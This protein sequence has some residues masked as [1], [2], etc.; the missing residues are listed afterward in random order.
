[1]SIERAI[2]GSF[3]NGIKGRNQGFQYYTYTLGYKDIIDSFPFIDS[4]VVSSYRAPSTYGYYEWF[5]G[6]EHNIINCNKASEMAKEE[7][8]RCFS[9]CKK[10]IGDKEKA[11]F[12]YAKDLGFDWTG[13]RP[14]TPYQC[15][16][17]CDL[18]DVTK[19]P[20]FYCSSPVVCCDILRECFFPNDN[21]V[22]DS[23]F[24]KNE[25]SLDSNNDIQLVHTAGFTNITLDEILNFINEEG[26][27]RLHTLKS[28]VTSLLKLKDGD[29][30]CRIVLADSKENNVMWIAALSYIFPV[31]NCLNLSFT[32]YGYSIT[33]FDINGV[34]VAALN[35]VSEEQGMPS[36]DYEFSKVVS[37]FS[38]YDFKE[39]YFAPNVEVED[40]L[41]MSMIENSFT[42]NMD[43]LLDAYKQYIEEFTTYRQLNSKYIW[44]YYLY[45]LLHTKMTLSNSDLQ[46]GLEFALEY[47]LETEKTLVLN[48]FFE[49][50]DKYSTDEE[51]IS[52]FCKY[53][54][55]L[56]TEKNILSKDIIINRFTSYI[57]DLIANDSFD[58]LHKFSNIVSLTEKICELSEGELETIIVGNLQFGAIANI[59][60]TVHDKWKKAYLNSAICYYI[61]SEKI[62][63]KKD[64]AL[65]NV[66]V[67]IVADIIENETEKELKIVDKFINQSEKIITETESWFIYNDAINRALLSKNYELLSNT[68]ITAI[69]KKY[70]NSDSNTKAA[71]V[72]T[73]TKYSLPDQYILCIIQSIS[74]LENFDDVLK[75]YTVLIIN[76]G[77]DVQAYVGLIKHFVHEGLEKICGNAKLSTQ[78]LFEAYEFFKICDEKCRSDFEYTEA[79]TLIEAYFSALLKEHDNFII[80]HDQAKELNYLYAEYVKMGGK[81]N[82]AI[83]SAFLLINEMSSNTNNKGK[84]IFTG[85]G[86]NSIDYSYLPQKRKSSFLQST[87]LFCSK[88]WANNE[89]APNFTGLF[90]VSDKSERYEA[91]SILLAKIANEFIENNNIKNRYRYIADLIEYGIVL[92]LKEYLN[93]IPSVI[94]S[95]VK[96]HNVVKLLKKDFDDKI[97][98]K[99]VSEL[100]EHV[101]EKELGDIIEK[102]MVEY[103]SKESK[104]TVGK[105]KKFWKNLNS[106]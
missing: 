56:C 42:V 43:K 51:A 95:K 33:D 106:Q 44:G 45:V 57:T 64:D 6:V 58:N 62:T 22:I 80:S 50:I 40:N 49:N 1:M 68:V 74:R 9:F 60:S 82:L 37:S 46:G 35:N 25:C 90:A 38:V 36:T 12:I 8:P 99:K 32:T 47:A 17:I 96:Q 26:E 88:Y 77:K 91:M 93:S 79:K 83:V 2:Y 11:V 13:Q 101:D 86:I 18:S 28:L 27:E 89:I 78:I 70:I 103:E 53:F 5:S 29:L 21:S 69:A 63:I 15:A 85:E 7:H 10:N 61:R 72:K 102:I 19:S 14:L 52:I 98:H 67:K 87:A 55:Q 73:V 16:T 94:S 75:N 65:Y 3:Q 104:T 23:S 66:V 105:I 4:M 71:I 31:K 81:D 24:L 48:C 100:I 97:H 54:K 92:C 34:Y 76:N 41:F 39:Q 20:V 59:V 84:C 30:S